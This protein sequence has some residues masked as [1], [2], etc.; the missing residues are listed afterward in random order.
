MT[1]Y[2]FNAAKKMLAVTC[3]LLLFVCDIISNFHSAHTIAEA[4][5]HC[6]SPK[7]INRGLTHGSVLSFTLF[8]LFINVLLG[9][10]YPPIH[11]SADE[12]THL[13]S[14]QLECRPSE[15]INERLRDN[16]ESCH[17]SNLSFITDLDEENL[18]VLNATKKELFYLSTHTNLAN[19]FTLFFNNT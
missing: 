10:T 6:P 1:E 19:M 4:D 11:S 8:L 5:S 9:G 2:L 16:T 15:Q 18:V 3:K 7:T 14:T 13:Y 17:T 12:T